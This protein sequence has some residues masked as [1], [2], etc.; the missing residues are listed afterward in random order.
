MPAISWR[1][2]RRKPLG[3][4]WWFTFYCSRVSNDVSERDIVRADVLPNSLEGE[5]TTTAVALLQSRLRDEHRHRTFGSFD[6]LTSLSQRIA[7]SFRNAP[8]PSGLTI[9]AVIPS[10]A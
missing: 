8:N 2:Q 6:A 3:A 10:L 1:E 4:I 9:L 5:G 7:S